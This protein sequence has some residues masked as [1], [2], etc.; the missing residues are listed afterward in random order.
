MIVSDWI[1]V[2]NLSLVPDWP[3]LG[4]VNIGAEGRVPTAPHEPTEKS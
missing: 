4:R 3:L 1:L 2:S